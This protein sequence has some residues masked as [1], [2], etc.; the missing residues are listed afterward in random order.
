MVA[1]VERQIVGFRTSLVERNLA[2][3]LP[4]YRG[5]R[6]PA[7]SNRIVGQIEPCREACGLTRGQRPTARI[8]F[9]H[10]VKKPDFG[11]IHL[12]TKIH[13][14]AVDLRRKID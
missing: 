3:A 13:F 7:N 12:P 2:L 8:T 4:T 5:R 14:S 6:H 9:V 10:T 1:M 11:L